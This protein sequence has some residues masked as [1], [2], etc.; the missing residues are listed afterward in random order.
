MSVARRSDK[1]LLTLSVYG[2]LHLQSCPLSQTVPSGQKLTL[3]FRGQ[4]FTS[5]QLTKSATLNR[6]LHCSLWQF[7]F[8]LEGSFLHSGGE[9]ARRPRVIFPPES[10]KLNLVTC[11]LWCRSGQQSEVVLHRPRQ[12]QQGLWAGGLQQGPR[13]EERSQEG[14]QEDETSH[15]FCCR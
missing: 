14:C 6:L 3:Y 15:L 13:Q 9:I 10:H 8:Y 1:F 4:L 12:V 2:I 5:H 7:L 11:S